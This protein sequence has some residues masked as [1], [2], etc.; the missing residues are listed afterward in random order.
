MKKEL[1]TFLLLVLLCVVVTLLLILPWMLST[2][3]EFTRRMFQ[4]VALVG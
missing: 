1:G 4:G 3:L 2:L